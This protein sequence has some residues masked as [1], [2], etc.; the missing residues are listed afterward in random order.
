MLQANHNEAAFAA[1]QRLVRLPARLAVI[2]ASGLLACLLAALP[3][4]WVLYMP[5][6]IGSADFTT[7]LVR[8]G[9][10]TA[11]IARTLAESGVVRSPLGFRVA[12][13]LLR[14]DGHLKAGEYSLSP[15]WSPA[16]IVEVLRSG[17]VVKYR[18]TIPE[19]Y[20]V[21]QIAQAL[22]AQGLVDE[23]EFI[24]M[25]LHKASEFSEIL[26]FEPAQGSLEGY[27]FPDTYYFDKTMT[28]RQIIQTM[29]SRFVE[30]VVPEYVSS[31]ER[32]FTLHQIVTLASII[33]KEAVLDEDRPRISAVFRNRLDRG[34]RLQSC[35]TVEYA[36]G[37]RKQHL[38][39]EDLAVDSPFNTYRAAGLPPGPISSPGLASIKAALNPADEDYLYFVAR[40]DG[41]HVFST[42]FKDHVNAKIRYARQA[43]TAAG[44]IQLEDR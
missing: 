39:E 35:A 18:V 9:S 10:S 25:A 21:K 28:V 19:G 41:G 6:K 27:L 44:N 40:G 1:V 22:S 7:V 23:D 29:V 33:E 12:A 8:K 3:I 32:K 15:G 26:G 43:L 17:H 38:T 36:L 2:A 30:V 14:A 34:M 24:S 20:T 11:A 37:Q 42:N 31:G 16:R 13:K 4:L 5:A